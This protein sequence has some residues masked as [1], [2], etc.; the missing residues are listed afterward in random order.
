M[1]CRKEKLIQFKKIVAIAK[2][3]SNFTVNLKNFNKEN[4]GPPPYRFTS[5]LE[6]TGGAALGD[7]RLDPPDASYRC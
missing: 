6:G 4:Q 1:K 5:V 7:P 2:F 3:E